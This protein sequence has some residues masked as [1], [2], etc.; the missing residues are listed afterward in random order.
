MPT[1]KQH[2]LLKK[3]TEETVA[4][5]WVIIGGLVTVWWFLER[6]ET[7]KWIRA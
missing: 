7:T 1:N 2:L 3:A 6:T 4:F 5:L